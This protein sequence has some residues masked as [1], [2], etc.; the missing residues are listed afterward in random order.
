M[1]IF[2]KQNPVCLHIFKKCRHICKAPMKCELLSDLPIRVVFKF[3]FKQLDI[4]MSAWLC[5]I[6]RSKI[7]ITC[8]LD[9]NWI[10]YLMCYKNVYCAA[11]TK[12]YS[13][14]SN[15]C[16]QQSVLLEFS[17][18]LGCVPFLLWPIFRLHDDWCIRIL[19]NG[20]QVSV[21]LF[22]YPRRGHPHHL[23]FLCLCLVRM[24]LV[25]KSKLGSCA[26]QIL[27]FAVLKF[28]NVAVLFFQLCYRVLKL[29]W[30]EKKMH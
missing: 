15:V 12:K 25:C 9:Q 18:S 20:S 3:T 27:V 6:A 16:V 4:F 17:L 19:H 22:W 11:A 2:R 7:L 29:S 10:G 30:R 1:K 28:W 21:I 26:N 8:E 14:P 23:C 13:L 5:V 24:M